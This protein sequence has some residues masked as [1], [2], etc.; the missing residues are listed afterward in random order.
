MLSLCSVKN[1]KII[2]GEKSLGTR[3]A[4]AD[5]ESGRWLATSP[6]LTTI[7]NFYR[8]AWTCLHE[9]VRT[10]AGDPSAQEE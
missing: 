3:D 4:D 9:Q 10:A 2:S 5:D 7:L 1:G 8:S 6:F